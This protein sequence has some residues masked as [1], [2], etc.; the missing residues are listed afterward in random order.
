MNVVTSKFYERSFEKEN[1]YYPNVIY[2]EVCVCMKILRVEPSR[3]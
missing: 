2:L 3:L 1:D